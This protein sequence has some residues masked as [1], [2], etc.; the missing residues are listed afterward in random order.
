MM[1]DQHNSIPKFNLYGEASGDIDSEF[2]HIESIAKRSAKEAWTIRSHRHGK[3]FQ[4]VFI[5]QGGARVLLDNRQL[6]VA[7]HSA[8]I[9]AANVVHGF[10]FTPGAEGFV[11]TVAEPLINQSMQSR[12]MEYLL[13]VTSQAHVVTFIPDSVYD[14]QL[15]RQLQDIYAEFCAY[16]PGKHFVIE[17][18]VKMVLMTLYRE[19]ERQGQLEKAASQDSKFA[20][21]CQLIEQHFRQQWHVEQYAQ[22]MGLSV[23]T[24]NRLCQQHKEMSAKRFIND[25]VFVEAKRKLLYTQANIDQ[26]AYQLGFEDPAYFSRFFKRNAKM[27]PKAYREIN[28]F[29]TYTL[30]H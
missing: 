26:I 4:M 18:L 9:V 16:R 15:L 11:L 8:V 12:A 6:S 13:K 25:R 14:V 23:S 19:I 27:S 17:W 7:S 22:A 21:F 28:P 1:D 29:D 10:E 20:K 5:R 24:L 30:G 2:V 3:L